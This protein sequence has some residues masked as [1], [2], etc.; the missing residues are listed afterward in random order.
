LVVVGS[1]FEIR[2]GLTFYLF[3]SCKRSAC[4]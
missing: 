4:H 3:R 2:K 1:V